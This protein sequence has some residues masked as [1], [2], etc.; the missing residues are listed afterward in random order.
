LEHAHEGTL[1]GYAAHP[2][3]LSAWIEVREQTPDDPSALNRI[4]FVVNTNE[5]NAADEARARQQAKPGAEVRFL[6]IEKW[7][8]SHLV[9]LLHVPREDRAHALEEVAENVDERS[10]TLTLDAQ[11]QTA[12][13]EILKKHMGSGLAAA[14]V[15]LDVDSGHTLVR[16]QW[17]DIDPSRPQDWSHELKSSDAK[18]MGTY[19]PWADKT[20]V[21]GFFQAGSIFKVFTSL[22]AARVDPEPALLDRLQTATCAQSTKR[23]YECSETDALG[24][25]Y[26][27]PGWSQ[28]IH[29]SHREPD[30]TVNLAKAL[31][32]SCNVYFAQLGLELGQQP[33]QDLAQAGVQA[34]HSAFDPGTAD[35]F[36]LA[37]TAYGQGA[38]TLNTAQAARLMSTVAAGGVLRMCPTDLSLDGS[39][40]ETRIAPASAMPPILSGLKKV[41]DSGTAA[42]F[43]ELEG[44]RVYGKTGTATDPG[45][46]D[47]G[48]WGISA[49]SQQVPHSWFLAII[50]PGSNDACAPQAPNR[51]AI[52]VVVPRGGS[53]DGA[54][55]TIAQEITIAAKALG[56]LDGVP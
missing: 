50:E 55:R 16:A 21:R 11:L 1:R 13:S 42:R 27:H 22:A 51:L 56:H 10:I 49:G 31:E 29:D 54:A 36:R 52:S 5:I 8:L 37:S 34:G 46:R 48:A 28:G 25:V 2:V 19:G 30:G 45:R 35:S 38:A 14:A 24:P 4:L 12:T 17:P 9:W 20:G 23:V 44:V 43:T 40:T 7:S 33:F 18:F 47:E 39:C 3:P 6:P 32:V 26:Q 41:I 15:V 53:G